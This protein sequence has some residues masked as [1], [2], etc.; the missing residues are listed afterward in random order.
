[1]T[2]YTTSAPMR[3]LI[4]GW[5]GCRLEPYADAVGVPTVGYGHTGDDVS[6]DMDPITQEVADQLL[7]ADL[8][9]FEDAVNGMVIDATSQQ[10]FDALVSFSYNLGE[11]SLRGST[12]LRMHNSG[13][14]QGAAGQFARWNHAGGQVLPGLTRRRAGEAAVYANGDYSGGTA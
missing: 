7:E 3:Q 2:S 14:Y 8:Q 10:Q 9:N 12:L 5:E 11:S 13:D 6:L 1:M 4:E